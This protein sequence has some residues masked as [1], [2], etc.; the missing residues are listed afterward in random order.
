MAAL[1]LC[2]CPARPRQGRQASPEPGSGQPGPMKKEAY[3]IAGR[4]VSAS[5][6]H[7]LA[8][9]TV[10]IVQQRGGNL[11][12]SVISGDDGGFAFED[13]SAGKFFMLGQRR[14]FISSAYNQH[15]QFSTAIVTGAGMDIDTE[16]LVL[17]LP[18]AA[19][20]TGRVVNEF[21]EPV[22]GASVT[23]YR[24]GYKT[25]RKEIKSSGTGPTDSFGEF[26]FR[27]LAAGKYFIAVR[28]TP[29]YAVATAPPN[30]RSPFVTGVDPALDVAYPL[31]FYG[32][33][34]KEDA[35]T[36]I[37]LKAGARFRADVHLSAVRAVRITLR[38]TPD[39]P[40]DEFSQLRTLVF[41]NVEQ[42]PAQIQPLPDKGSEV[43]GLAPGLYQ[44]ETSQQDSGISHLSTVDVTQGAVEIDPQRSAAEASVNLGIVLNSGE[45]LPPNS[46]IV[47]LG[48][49]MKPSLA[50]LDGDGNTIFKAVQP[51]DYRFVISNGNRL[52]QT[53]AIE[54][55][56]KRLDQDH[57]LLAPGE[58][59]A[60]KLVVA[61]T[62][63]SVDGVAVRDGK[64]MAGAMIVLVPVDAIGNADLFRR[65][66]SD[67]D[68]T[69]ALINVAA[70]R[71]IVVAIE[72]GW[73]LEWAKPEVLARFL[74]KGT[75]VTIS[76]GGPAR[77]LLPA[78]VPVQ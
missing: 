16:S 40:P 60:L 44:F 13:L 29:W 55:D 25:G 47:L 72:N 57:R 24:E 77:V 43:T 27:D 28:A 31:T 73:E 58:S 5:D 64:P 1:L 68:G 30:P 19:S 75:A 62:A 33:A 36:P 59:A 76:A 56:G 8:G 34:T 46:Q 38:A 9:A 53:V 26:S 7:P 69:F 52:W 10:S 42:V 48:A 21:A 14:G 51:G 23:L 39:S 71:Y 65:D 74:P 22:Q 67:L 41:G 54:E 6:G 45:K 12:A 49:G 61:E 50:G 78:A 20:V 4:V 66:Q 37:L 15:G 18:P 63:K 35:A 2:A 70:G 17:R 3:R 32:D 11:K